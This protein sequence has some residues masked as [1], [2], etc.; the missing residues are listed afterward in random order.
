M[1]QLPGNGGLDPRALGHESDFVA[2]QFAIPRLAAGGDPKSGLERGHESGLPLV[3]ESVLRP[4][5][6]CKPELAPL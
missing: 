3:S 5:V 6:E 2:N 1:D 4:S